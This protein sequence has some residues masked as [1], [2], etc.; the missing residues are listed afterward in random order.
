MSY[1]YNKYAKGMKVSNIEHIA[2]QSLN[3]SKKVKYTKAPSYIHRN[4]PIMSIIYT[5][6][7]SSKYEI[8]INDKAD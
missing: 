8:Q 1:I 4:D 7:D 3:K 5:N 6:G 2:V